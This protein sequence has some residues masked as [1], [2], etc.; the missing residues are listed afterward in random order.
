MNAFRIT[1]PPDR[2]SRRVCARAAALPLLAAGLFGCGTATPPGTHASPHALG[3]NDPAWVTL[4]TALP[5]PDTDRLNYDVR[6]RTLTLYDLPGNDRWLVRLPGE[7]AG[8]QV[9]PRHRIPEVDPADV[10]V[11]YTRPGFQPSVPVSVKQILDSGS[12]HV[13]MAPR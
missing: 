13:S 2:P 11:Y 7:T 3:A 12:T 9:T 8:R 10:L 6:T 1:R 4:R 5:A